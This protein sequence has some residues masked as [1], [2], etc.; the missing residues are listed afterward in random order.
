MKKSLITLAIAL[1]FTAA[2]C[3]A[4]YSFTCEVSAV[5]GTQ[6]TLDCKAKDAKKLEVGSKAKVTETKKKRAIEGC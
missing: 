2:S 4:A 1:A 6:V 5:D 3:V